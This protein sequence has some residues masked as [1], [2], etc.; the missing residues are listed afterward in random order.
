MVEKAYLSLF[1][2]RAYAAWLERE[3]AE[4]KKANPKPKTKNDTYEAE[5]DWYAKEFDLTAHWIKSK[6]G[7]KV[8][9]A[10]DAKA[11]KFIYPGPVINAGKKKP[12]LVKTWKYRLSAFFG[13][14]FGAPRG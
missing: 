4:F 13:N 9:E 14:N 11:Q 5:L 10:L 3:L 12:P 8:R 1:Q 7:Q 6:E 2:L